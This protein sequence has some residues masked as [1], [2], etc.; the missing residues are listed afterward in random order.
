MY[1]RQEMIQIGE[2]LRSY[3]DFDKHIYC[4]DAVDPRKGHT[5]TQVKSRVSLNKKGKWYAKHV[6][7]TGQ[8]TPE[9]LSKATEFIKQQHRDF[10]NGELAK[11]NCQIND[12]PTNTSKN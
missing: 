8:Y 1:S 10:I 6:G 5:Y 2:L 7:R 11:F 4:V 3:D 9:D 12:F